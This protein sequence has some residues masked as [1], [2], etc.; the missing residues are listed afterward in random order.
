MNFMKKIRKLALAMAAGTVVLFS[1]AANADVIT[2]VEEIDQ[3]V[4]G[5]LGFPSFSWTHTLEGFTLGTAVSGELWIDMR[6]DERDLCVEWA[7]FPFISPCVQR[8]GEVTSVIV[9]II[10]FLDGELFHNPNFDFLGDLG[11]ISLLGLNTTGTLT[12]TLLPTGDFWVGDSVLT[13]TTRD[14]SEVQ[15]SEP[16]TLALL[17]LGLAGIG[18]AT[19]RRKNAA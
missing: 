9:G 2:D 3:R 10:D 18:F 4:S 1:S 11:P 19:R 14:A 16:G 5:F 12:V 15:V 8:A 6:D 13:V 7:G 17:G